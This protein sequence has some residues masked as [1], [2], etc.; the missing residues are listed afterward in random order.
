M[1]AVLSASILFMTLI[2]LLRPKFI[3]FSPYYKYTKKYVSD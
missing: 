1:Y 2:E 3:L